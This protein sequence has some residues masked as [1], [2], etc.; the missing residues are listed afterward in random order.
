MSNYEKLRAKENFFDFVNAPDSSLFQIFVP[1]TDFDP[2]FSQVLELA[3][4]KEA[5]LSVRSLFVGRH[6]QKHCKDM[7]HHFVSLLYHVKRMLSKKEIPVERKTKMIDQILAEFGGVAN[8]NFVADIVHLSSPEEVQKARI[9]FDRAAHYVNAGDYSSTIF[10][11]IVDLINIMTNSLKK[12]ESGEFI[13]IEFLDMVDIALFNTSEAIVELMGDIKYKHQ[14]HHLKIWSDI[15][16]T[17]PYLLWLSVKDKGTEAGVV[18]AYSIEEANAVYCMD[19]DAQLSDSSD[20]RLK[21][22]N[23][24]NDLNLAFG[25]HESVVP[26]KKQKKVN[27]SREYFKRKQKYIK[28]KQNGK[29]HQNQ[30]SSRI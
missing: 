25:T 20:V 12:I 5:D 2:V 17:S 24:F 26:S 30:Q 16:N 6:V 29:N 1:G 4:Y 18:R 15:L 21:R 11:G 27:K 23:V 19:F 7:A 9:A 28:Q 14:T 8:L 22:L 10:N 3:G 13:S